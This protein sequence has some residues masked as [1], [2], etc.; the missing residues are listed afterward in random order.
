VWVLSGH[1]LRLP[2]VT[3]GYHADWDL[4]RVVSGSD[5][6]TVSLSETQVWCKSGGY[7]PAEQSEKTP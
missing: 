7:P 2:G 5:T 6:L 4:Y 3:I 1:G